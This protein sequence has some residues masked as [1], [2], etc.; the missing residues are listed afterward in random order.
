[1]RAQLPFLFLAAAL[2]CGAQV[3]ADY[4]AELRE[5]APRADGIRHV[6]SAALVERLKALRVNTYVFLVWK[7]STD[8]DDLR[9]EFLPAARKAAIDVLVYIVPPTECT[10]TCSLPFEKDYVRWGEEV[11]RLALE[12]PNLKGLAIDDFE[13]SLKD[14]FTPDYIR[15]I[16][17]AMTEINP[18]TLLL[19]QVYWRSFTPE[20]VNAYVPLVDGLIFAYRDDPTTNTV[21]T[22]SL[23]QQLQGAEA[24]MASKGKSL[25]LMV[26]THPLGHL[27]MSPDVRYVGEIVATGIE[28]TQQGKL[29]GVVT[30]ALN[31]GGHDPK[32]ANRAHSGRGVAGFQMPGRSTREGAYGTI[33]QQVKV[34]ADAGSYRLRFRHTGTHHQRFARGN[35]SKQ[36][37]VDGK[38]VWE[39]DVADDQAGRWKQESVDLS[40]ALAGKKA[41]ILEFRMTDRRD[42]DTYWTWAAFDDLEA[43]GFAIRDPGFESP[44]AWRTDANHPAFLAM[45]QVFDPERSIKIFNEV[46]RLYLNAR[47]GNR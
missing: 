43:Q 15:S 1:M 26:Y 31:K 18:R 37:L 45:V 7:Q 2:S 11:A 41:A 10:P 30:Y 14:V 13:Y 5:A 46:S 47:E 35:R 36:V 24:M 8:W 42:G 4:D 34:D 38:V 20:F 29:A 12:Y 27:P 32:E 25:V 19:P 39:G 9:H 6:D 21:R 23:E 16:K 28:H 17:A 22:A 40:G 33:G 3:L 44:E